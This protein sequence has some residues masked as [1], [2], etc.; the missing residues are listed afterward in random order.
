MGPPLRAGEVVAPCE[1]LDAIN[2]AM[3][4]FSHLVAWEAK[5]IIPPVLHPF[6]LKAPNTF[7]G[8]PIVTQSLP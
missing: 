2:V 7:I 1:D 6:F 8:D 4:V 5:T 3:I